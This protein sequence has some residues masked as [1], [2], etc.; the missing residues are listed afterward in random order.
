VSKPAGWNIRLPYPLEFFV[1]GGAVAAPSALLA[2]QI[3]LIPQQKQATAFAVLGLLA[4]VISLP[5]VLRGRM[6]SLRVLS[7]ERILDR[8]LKTGLLAL[9][10]I[11]FLTYSVRFSTTLILKETLAQTLIIFLAAVWLARGF[12]RGRLEY[13]RTPY[14]IWVGLLLVLAAVSLTWAPARISPVRDLFL[15][16]SFWFL[17]HVLSLEM[18]SPRFR[19]Q[20]FVLVAGTALVIAF[21]ALGQL[22]RWPIL[23]GTDFAGVWAEGIDPRL[24]VASTIGHNISVATFFLGVGFLQ[25]GW[26]LSAR[27]APRMI[28][29]LVLFAVSALVMFV[30]ETRG[31]Y[32]ALPLS[33]AALGVLIY[34]FRGPGGSHGWAVARTEAARRLVLLALFSGVAF[35]VLGI[36]VSRG[37]RIDPLG[38]LRTLRPDVLT[39]GTRVRLWTL[40]MDMIRDHPIRG[41]G[42]QSF[43]FEYPFY[44]ASYFEENPDSRMV[45]T[46]RHTDRVHNEYLQVWVELGAPGLLLVLGL[47]FAHFRF[48]WRQTREASPDPDIARDDMLRTVLFAG[49]L[50]ALMDGF[51]SFYAH[52]PSDALMLVFLLSGVVGMSRPQQ[53][54]GIPLPGLAGRPIF[55]RGLAFLMFPIAV[56]GA[57]FGPSLLGPLIPF[58]H[59]LKGARGPVAHA[60]G[61]AIYTPEERNLSSL[62]RRIGYRQVMLFRTSNPDPGMVSEYMKE[63]QGLQRT[64]D[65]LRRAREVSPYRGQISYYAGQCL[66]RYAEIYGQLVPVLQRMGRS[67]D[68]AKAEQMALQSFQQ[69]RENLRSSTEEYQFRH[70]YYELAKVDFYLAVRTHARAE[71]KRAQGETAEADA[72]AARARGLMQEA[73][74]S[75]RTAARMYPLSVDYQHD[76]AKFLLTVKKDDRAALESWERAYRLDPSIIES[77]LIPEA[78]TQSARNSRE[79]I[80]AAEGLYRA[81]Y[82]LAREFRGLEGEIQYGDRLCRF[83]ESQG[84]LDRLQEVALE[85]NQRHPDRSDAFWLATAYLGRSGHVDVLRDTIFH[86]LEDRALDDPLFERC[87]QV[88][89]A[90]KYWGKPRELLDFWE[91]VAARPVEESVRPRLLTQVA[92]RR[93]SVAGEP[94]EAMRELAKAGELFQNMSP[95]PPTA[96]GTEFPNRSFLFQMPVLLR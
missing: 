43:K 47:M 50:G 83:Y 84:R 39:P 29:G 60:L 73:E 54:R 27:N 71:A 41:I 70:I 32:V 94:S 44:Q 22:Y 75:F 42:F 12:V 31:V 52:V 64:I 34:F 78:R 1:A 23:K 93:L 92:Y 65:R 4:L 14:N 57:Y 40:S 69:A 80:E 66:A 8:T 36:F 30:S 37:E 63:V 91:E 67:E 28:A 3:G 10:P 74:A 77:R 17:F 72:M 58:E 49:I 26:F 11:V 79:A 19:R 13:L 96:F 53:V 24:K 82:E 5:F 2:H 61:D 35:S 81:A 6:E 62:F 55:T 95:E 56:A 59:F 89:L 25:L 85:V 76:L 45:P 21:I 33:L 18:R 7:L 16:G 90:Y 20:V 38:R 86:E 15:F 51:F 9:F 68:A 87:L 48:M 88:D 46:N